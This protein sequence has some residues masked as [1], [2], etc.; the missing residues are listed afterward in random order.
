MDSNPSFGREVERN[1]SPRH[2]FSPRGKLHQT[3][4][5]IAGQS[6]HQLRGTRER[7]LPGGRIQQL[8]SEFGRNW[9]SSS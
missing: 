3:P 6:S 2:D 5:H 9:A 8:R 4:Q 7:A 1:V